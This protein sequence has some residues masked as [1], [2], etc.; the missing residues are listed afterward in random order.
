MGAKRNPPEER[1]WEHVNKNGPIPEKHP[2]LGNCWLWTASCIPQG[3][4]RFKFNGKMGYAHRFILGNIPNDMEVNHLCEI[5][6]CVRLS[7][8]E[9]TTR[10]ANVQYGFDN[11]RVFSEEH[12]SNL[13]EAFKKAA[14]LKTPE[15]R[16]ELSKK[17]WETR[18]MNG[19]P[20]MD[21]TGTVTSEETKKKMSKSQKLAWEIRRANAVIL[22]E[23]DR[24][25][26]ARVS[27]TTDK[28]CID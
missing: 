4:G 22:I 23:N 15:E 19:S 28:S 25:D 2:E 1:F 14:A 11:G 17:A 8:L 9:I 12:R 21:R 3:Y 5:K 26:F 6:N 24:T 20:L 18:K 7:H 13:S 10:S 27:P 16:S